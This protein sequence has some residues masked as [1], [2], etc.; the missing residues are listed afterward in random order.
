MSGPKQSD[1]KASESEKISAAVSL[2]QKEFFDGEI[3]PLLEKDLRRSSTEDQISYSEGIRNLDV[4]SALTE[5]LTNLGV[6]RG[7]ETSADIASISAGQLIDAQ[8]T[9]AVSETSDLLSGVKAGQG[10]QSQ[11]MSG[12]RYMANIDTYDTLQAG[13]RKQARDQ[14]LFTSIGQPLAKTYGSFVGGNRESLAKIEA[15]GNKNK[16]GDPIMDPNQGYF[17]ALFT[18]IREPK[19]T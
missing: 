3:M 14:Q 10:F 13:K 1:Y 7:I 17:N 9:G 11:T 8:K 4:M 18:G 12:M 6:A 5:N 19:I 2:K 15:E 16:S